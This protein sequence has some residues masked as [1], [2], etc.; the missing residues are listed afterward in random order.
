[1]QAA[2]A[3]A[4]R[5]VL[6]GFELRTEVASSATRTAT[7]IRAARSCGTRVMKLIAERE[8]RALAA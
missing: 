3:E 5:I 7:W 4:S 8:D 2:M 6:D 1:M